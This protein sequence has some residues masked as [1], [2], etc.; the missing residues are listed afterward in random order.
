VLQLFI[1]EAPFFYYNVTDERIEFCVEEEILM[2]FVKKIGSYL[3]EK[4]SVRIYPATFLMTL[5]VYLFFPERGLVGTLPFLFLFSLFSY[6]ILPDWKICLIVSAGVSFL[7]GLMGSIPDPFLYALFS[8]LCTLC[9]VLFVIGIRVWR[10]KGRRSG[11][12]LSLLFLALGVALPMLYLGTPVAHWNSQK[13]MDEYLLRRYPDQ[14]FSDTVLHYD[15]REKAYRATVEYANGENS[16]TSLILFYEDR[17][18]DGFG[19][20]YAVWMMDIRKSELISVFNSEAPCPVVL[21]SLGF[22]EEGKELSFY[23]GSF[24]TLEESMIPLM[25]YSATFRSVHVTRKSFI[26]DVKKM[27]EFLKEKQVSFGAITF[28]GQQEDTPVYSCRITPETDP[29]EVL[30]LSQILK[31]QSGEEAEARP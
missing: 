21:E 31:D 16:L 27:L 5:G 4:K 11:L 7:Y 13:R 26:D 24:G 17:V 1:D 25:H 22:T 20:D 18:E 10:R 29:E 23:P 30:Y 14:V 8:V 2:E 19:Q 3:P 12:A 28:I 9:A 15:L 6:L